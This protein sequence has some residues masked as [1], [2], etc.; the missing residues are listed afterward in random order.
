MKAKNSAHSSGPHAA[1]RKSDRS[2]ARAK[3]TNFGE[4]IRSRRR[5]LH[6]TQVEVASRIK[7]S[8]SYVG[9]LESGRRHPSNLIV[10][11]LARVLRLDKREL[12]SLS[13]PHSDASLS[14]QPDGAEVNASVWDQ[15]RKDKQLRRIHSISKAEMK[16]LSWVAVFGCDLGR[17]GSLR[18]LIY[19]LNTIRRAVGR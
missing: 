17:F 15:F 9:L 1:K 12:F 13:N 6:L 11:R 10:T 16:M 18:D 7:T 5:E 2:T 19:M 8:M 3:E 4:V 14:A